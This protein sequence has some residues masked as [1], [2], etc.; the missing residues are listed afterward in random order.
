MKRLCLTPAAAFV[1]LA[2]GCATTTAAGPADAIVQT[3]SGRISGTFE[4]G[5]PVY[6]GVPFAK[7]PVG[8]LR[9]KPPQPASWD[10]TLDATEFGPACPQPVNDDGSPNF[11][12]YAGPVSE[13]CL[14]INIWTPAEATDAPIM[15]WLFGGGGVVGAGSVDTYNG[16]SFARDGVILATINYRLGAL[17]GFAHPAISADAKDG[18]PVTNIHLLDAIAALQWMKDNA[19]AFGGDPDSIIVFGESAGATMTANIVTS[20]LAEGLIDKAIIQ[21]SGSLRAGS[22]PLEMAEAR[23]GRLAGDLGLSSTNA[24]LQELQALD[25]FAILSNREFGRGSRTV[26]DPVVKPQSIIEAFRAGTEIDIPMI[27]GTN[28]DEGRLAGTQEVATLAQDGAPV[29]QYF[30]HYVASSMREQN[31]NGAPHA[32]E[33]PFVFDTLNRY[34]RV[35]APTEEDQRAADTLH[36][37]WVAFAKLPAG[38]T[39][40]DCGDGFVWPA[41]TDAN[42]QTVAIFEAAPRLGVASGL[43]SPP[44]GAAPGRTSRPGS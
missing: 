34:P 4:T 36:G 42:G 6:R 31:P 10:G 30:F 1:I 17:G 20:P 38:S 44:N 32:H 16:S 26:E 25:A 35:P 13:D 28:S 21:S 24:T 2:G 29:W 9:W 40:I 5:M 19:E 12:G 27:I 18:T 14:T 37:C 7:A 43:K 11:G 39:G 8:A 33:I 22:L 15:V 23:G 41:R 3:T